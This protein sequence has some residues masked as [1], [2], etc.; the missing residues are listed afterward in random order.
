MKP[1]AQTFIVNEP[2]SGVDAV[3]L[4]KVDFY[5]RNKSST[6]GVELQVRETNNG[7]PTN[8]ILP[9]ASKI[10]NASD[11]NTSLD[12]SAV[13]T[14]E[15]ST[16]V[17]LRSNE[18]FAFVIIPEG[19]NPDYN[20]WIAELGGND[21][22]NN[23][24]IYTNNQLGSL[25]ISSNDL[26]FT[27]IQNE[28]LKYTAYVASF[29]ASTAEAVFKN[30][31]T[32]HLVVTNQIGSFLPQEKLVVSNNYLKISSLTIS[33]SNTFTVGETVFQPGG[34]AVA[35]LTQ[36]TARGTVYFANTTRVLMSNTSGAFSTANTVRGATS[37]NL[38]STP[39]FANQSVVTSAA[40]NV[41]TVPDS[42]SSTGDFTVNNFIYVGKNTGANIQIL[43]ITATNSTSRTIT[44]D[45]NVKFTE[46]NAIIGRV[47]DDAKLTG[48][49]SSLTAGENMFLS[50]TTSSANAT[51]NFTGSNGAIVIGRT[52]G[53][54]VVI[55]DVVDL[56]YENITCMIPDI[57]PNLTNIVWAFKGTANN[58]GR[59]SDGN[60]IPI[61]NEIPY[62]FI[63]KTRVIM[64][65]SNEF[66]N[67]P[68]AGA[69]NSSLIVTAT[70]SSS[71]NKV[72][73]YIDTIRN[74]VTTTHNLVYPE[75]TLSGYIMFYSNT[76]SNFN[77]G[78]TIQQ[79][80]TTVTSNGTVFFSNSTVLHITN[81]TSSNTSNLSEF[82]LSNTIIYNASLA[83]NATITAI[84]SFNETS[85]TTSSASRYVSKN[86]IL[87]E[88]QDAEDLVT[89]LTA[90]RP[91]GTDLKI[92]G[93]L[94]S[95][96]DSDTFQNK[97]W[98][99]LV[100]TTSS[101]LISSLVNLQDFVELSYELPTSVQIIAN[102]ATVNSTSA[103]V[104]VSSTASFKAGDFVYVN[105]NATGRMNVRRVTGI[106]NTTTLIVSSNLSIVSTNAAI[107]IIPGLQSRTGAFK[108]A[109]NNGISRY[110]STNDAVFETFKTFAVKIVLVSNNFH[111]IP[112]ISDVRCLALQV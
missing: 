5:F 21:V 79:S 103:N 44:T 59:T 2:E 81:V 17:V 104:N 61:A 111:I 77:I 30:H 69:G 54:S 110:I 66:Q 37:N 58:A 27:P 6:F 40:C 8:K 25:F 72:T 24:P 64:S 29:T 31:N 36:A 100:E 52:S 51:S 101:S 35:N 55:S 23:T 90:Y 63:D 76:N 70:L 107:G 47:K 4:T 99:A 83:V 71:N 60:G 11:V 91:P 48:N 97:E 1:I 19:G 26:N 65:R 88:G 45:G 80:N 13:T 38:S 50:L 112:K 16:P 82:N 85:N 15:F 73:P 106:S 53:A 102:S 56:Q 105:D 62:D 12:A 9:Y 39:S 108:Y 14:F 86:V 68:S 95:T 75:N 49:F 32:E 92:Y 67:P 94:L 93:K 22:T 84:S 10:L 109:N 34:T 41:I 28:S 18:Q 20:I 3:F 43:Q 33:G 96:S 42:S 98:S 74:S 7:F 78:D 57:E 87:A 46:T 89:Y